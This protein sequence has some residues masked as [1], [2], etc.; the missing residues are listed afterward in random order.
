MRLTEAVL[1][2]CTS[3]GGLRAWTWM[4]NLNHPPHTCLQAPVVVSATSGVSKSPGK[5]DARPD[6]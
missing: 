1:K 3:N 5:K 6:I 2:S 4:A